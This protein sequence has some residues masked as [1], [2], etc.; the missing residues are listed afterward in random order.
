MSYVRSLYTMEWTHLKKSAPE[1]CATLEYL[2]EASRI[3]VRE[4]CRPVFVTICHHEHNSLRLRLRIPF[5]HSH[6]YSI[7]HRP[8]T[9]PVYKVMCVAGPR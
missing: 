5:R 2:S 1:H 8:V 4:P 7:P 6:S 9:V 3:F